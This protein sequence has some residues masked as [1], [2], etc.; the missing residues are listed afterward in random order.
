YK[1]FSEWNEYFLPPFN[2]V[3]EILANTEGIV[4][5]T[6]AAGFLQDII[7]GFGGIRILE[8][9][10]KIDPLLPENISQLIFK[11]IFFRNKVY[12]LDIR[13][14][15]DREIFRLREIYNE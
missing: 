15:N 8:D 13:R 14:E 9:G 4:F 3:R 12:R 7:Y 5:L 11:K 1:I 10:L 6:A 2:V